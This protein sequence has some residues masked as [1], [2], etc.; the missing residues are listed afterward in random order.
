MSA[1]SRDLDW[2]AP[3]ALVGPLAV[4]IVIRSPQLVAS[5]CDRNPLGPPRHDIDGRDPFCANCS[6]FAIEITRP[7][8]PTRFFFHSNCGL[9]RGA[10]TSR[11][12]IVH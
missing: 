7:V 10:F 4:G 2:P 1:F 9:K 11:P 12:V 6:P 8:W 3:G 5:T